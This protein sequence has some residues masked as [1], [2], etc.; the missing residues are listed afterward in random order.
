MRENVSTKT[1]CVELSPI[2][3]MQQQQQQDKP[4]ESIVTK[5][6]TST[7]TSTKPRHSFPNEMKL[8]TKWSWSFTSFYR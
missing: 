8:L 4:L 2:R 3:M 6:T 5:A 1:Y 7:T